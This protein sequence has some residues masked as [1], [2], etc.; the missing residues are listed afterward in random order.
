MIMATDGR[1]KDVSGSVALQNP[2]QISDNNSSRYILFN[3]IEF[4]VVGIEGFAFDD[5]ENF[6]AAI[7]TFECLM[8]PTADRSYFIL[9]DT[10][11]QF[12]T[13][14]DEI[15]SNIYDEYCARY[16]EYCPIP[17]Y[18]SFDFTNV[19]LFEEGLY[20]ITNVSLEFETLYYTFTVTDNTPFGDEV[21][22]LYTVKALSLPIYATSCDSG[23]S[24]ELEAR[25]FEW[26]QGPM[27]VW[28]FF[29]FILIFFTCCVTCF[30]S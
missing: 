12:E 8:D 15:E 25:I 23:N 9:E 13:I 7:A 28:F 2:C 24:W 19:P 16:E 26:T 18:P 27:Q 11:I 1:S 20:E 10:E 14:S 30:L 6:N 4:M 17:L 3:D 22:T 21:E 29:L 5:D